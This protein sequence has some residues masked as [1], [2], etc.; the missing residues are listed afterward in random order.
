[1]NPTTTAVLLVVIGLLVGIVSGMLGIGGGVLVIP[2]LV[3]LFG[4]SHER[5]VGTSLAMLLPPI[6][7]F[8]FMEYYRHGNVD[9]RAAL[10]LALGFAVGA[11]IGGRLVNQRM[12][13][14]D[15]LRMFFAFLL[16]Y[17]AGSILFGH[18]ESRVWAATKTGGLMLAAGVAYVAAKL[19]G[20]RLE[21]RFVAREVFVAGL[22]ESLAPDYEI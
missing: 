15:T 4:F 5:A 20:K 13:D 2:A 1:M 18:S 8:A 14:S 16:L 12:V 21:R 7:I 11:Y 6:G 19:I 3:F 17:I 22:G 10:L 9:I